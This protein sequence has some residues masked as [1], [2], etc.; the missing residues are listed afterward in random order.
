[1]KPDKDGPKRG[2]AR[3]RET[4][5]FIPTKVEITA[6]EQQHPIVLVHGYFVFLT[7]I[8]KDLDIDLLPFRMTPDSS[9]VVLRI[10]DWFFKGIPV[11][12]IS[13][14]MVQDRLVRLFNTPF[15]P[16]PRAPF[17]V[18]IRKLPPSKRDK[19]VEAMMKQRLNELSAE[20]PE[21]AYDE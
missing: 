16:T 5:N 15:E 12:E 2:G 1:M 10:P 6:D 3:S 21:E 13:A 17:D 9:P 11:N 7:K 19:A 14:K 20:A 18:P 4:W 8:A